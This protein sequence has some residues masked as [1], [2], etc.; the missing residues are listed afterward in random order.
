[1]EIL[2]TARLTC[3]SSADQRLQQHLPDHV[4][5]MLELDEHHLALRII[6]TLLPSSV[7]D[8][9]TTA[10]QVQAEQLRPHVLHPEFASWHL[11]SQCNQCLYEMTQNPPPDSFATEAV[12]FVL[13]RFRRDSG[14]IS[15]KVSTESV[16]AASL[17]HHVC[18][19]SSASLQLL[20]V[21]S[22]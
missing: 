20:L 10:C 16:E 19:G 17:P 13:N 18:A 22:G 14:C 15:E 7:E 6:G 3:S 9:A 11:K 12:K 5:L 8:G 2:S 1:M 4:D 21:W